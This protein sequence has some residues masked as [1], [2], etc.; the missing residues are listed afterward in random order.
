MGSRMAIEYC[1]E[2]GIDELIIYHDYAG[3]GMWGDDQWKAN[4]DMTREY[5]AFVR[6]ARE[7]MKI[8]FV[9]VKAHTGDK[10]NEAADRLAKSALGL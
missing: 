10:Y 3:I 2:N 5:K 7:K 6:E 1:L 9:K 4:L 8:S